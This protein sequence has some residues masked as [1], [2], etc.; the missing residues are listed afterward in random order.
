MPVTSLLELQL[1]PDSVDAGL[2]ILR[3]TLVATRAFD[4]CLSVLVIQ[5][6]ADPAHL[7]LVESWESVAHDDA[8]RAWRASVADQSELPAVLTQPPRLTVAQTRE[9]V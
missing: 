3:R 5:D 9:D 2:D 7:I 8:Y 4:G 6:H 1:K